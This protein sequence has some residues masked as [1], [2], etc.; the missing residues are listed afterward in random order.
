MKKTKVAVVEDSEK[1]SSVPTKRSK[2]VVEQAE[3]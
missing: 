1:T 3:A 2:Q